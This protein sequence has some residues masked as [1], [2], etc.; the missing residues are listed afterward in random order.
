MSCKKAFFGLPSLASVRRARQTTYLAAQH[1][2]ALMELRSRRL[3]N[4]VSLDEVTLGEAPLV[5]FLTA[6]E[7]LSNAE[8]AYRRSEQHRLLY[9]CLDRLPELYPSV[10]RTY[11]LQELDIR[12]G[13]EA[14]GISCSAFKSRLFRGRRAL[15]AL[16]DKRM[17]KQRRSPAGDSL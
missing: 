12:Q 3:R 15:S 1:C 11:Y 7:A 10:L 4:S 2:R 8:T 5:P 13:A 14:L 6:P 17:H 9:D 16:L